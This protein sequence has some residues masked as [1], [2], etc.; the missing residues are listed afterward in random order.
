MASITASSVA[1][2]VAANSA[3][4]DL[5]GSS[6][7]LRGRSSRPNELALPVDRARKISP[8]PSCATEPVRALPRATRRATRF[9]WC[10]N[11]GASVITT[12]ITESRGEAHLAAA[13]MLTNRHAQDH[14]LRGFRNSPGQ[15]RPP[16][17]PPAASQIRDALPETG[18][19][20][21]KRSSRTRLDAPELQRPWP[22]AIERC[23][24]M[25]VLHMEAIDIVEFS[26]IGL[27]HDGQA[28]GFGQT[29]S[30]RPF[31]DGVVTQSSECVLVIAT[32]PSQQPDF[33]NPRETC[34]LAATI[35]GKSACRARCV[36]SGSTAWQDC[37]DP[38]PDRTGPLL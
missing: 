27:A 31:D 22:G 3:S 10:G 36:G 5:L 12:A 33:L 26:I 14:Q 19:R 7:M 21:H 28:P 16:S 34:Q 35:E 32:G 38:R 20:S 13:Q 23:E 18:P 8:D 2:T 30:H 17:R 11:S 15:T 9:S 29:G 24:D 25:R 1:S 37:R 4:S 6:T